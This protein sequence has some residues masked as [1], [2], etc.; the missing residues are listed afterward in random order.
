MS[1]VRTDE[2]LWTKVK[3]MVLEGDRGGL[4]GEWSA[5]KAQ[6]AVAEYKSRGGKYMGEKSKDNSLVKWTEEDWGYIN[7]KPGNRYLPR[8]VRSALTPAQA[9]AENKAK[10]KATSEGKQ[11]ASYTKSVSKLMSKSKK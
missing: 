10:H 1:A 4:R 11:R 3:K 6:I 8:K 9:A 5:R 7:G 2:V